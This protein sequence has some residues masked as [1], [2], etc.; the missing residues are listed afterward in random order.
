MIERHD[1]NRREWGGLRSSTAIGPR[2]LI[3]LLAAALLALVAASAASAHVQRTSGRSATN[4]GWI[5]FTARPAG[6][7]SEQIFRIQPSGKGLKKLTKGAYPA[8]DPAFSPDGSRVAFAR[9]GAGIF[10]MKVDGS[11]TRQLTRNGRDSFP[12]WSPDGKQIAFIRPLGTG[13]KI[14]VMSAS[15]AGARQLRL[16]P[17]AGRPSWTSR[18]L[19]IPT[20]GELV[21]IDPVSGRV[22]RVFSALIDASIGQDTTAVSPN[23]ATISFVGARPPDPGDTGCGE[24]VPC[25]RFA[26]FT[27]VLRGH[28]M[29][30]TFKLNGGPASFSPDGKSLVY[31]E[32]NHL[33]L[34]T[35]AS[36]TP[37]QITAGTLALTTSSPPVLQPR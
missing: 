25:Q 17:D 8:E 7:G 31:V 11:A 34:Q 1:G 22:Q 9:I 37:K 12:V 16:A 23:L 5:L 32:Q 19:L 15:G 14:F 13:W 6:F 33:V 21:K 27:Q 29:P 3:L 4:P 24:G 10:S 35:L 26:L 18:G 28:T 20:N 36:G 30:K 2:A